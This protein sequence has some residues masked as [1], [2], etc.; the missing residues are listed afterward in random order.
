[1][2]FELKKIMKIAQKQH[3]NLNN[4]LAWIF[5]L[6]AKH[7]LA[8]LFQLL[9]LVAVFSQKPGK[10]HYF[11]FDK[12]VNVIFFIIVY[13]TLTCYVLVLSSPG[14]FWQLEASQQARQFD[15]VFSFGS[16]E[17]PSEK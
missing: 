2:G 8:Q 15:P 3:Q 11:G 1:M 4:P 13:L 12:I 6:I 10:K 9:L 16:F 5:P 14:F 17:R 7:P